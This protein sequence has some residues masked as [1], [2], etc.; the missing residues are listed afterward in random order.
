VNLPFAMELIQFGFEP[1]PRGVLESFVDNGRPAAELVK[2]LLVQEFSVSSLCLD[3]PNPTALQ[4]FFAEAE[5]LDTR[6]KAE[7]IL[8]HVTGSTNSS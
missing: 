1:E 2:A 6:T 4:L 7:T 3:P 5:R 8:K